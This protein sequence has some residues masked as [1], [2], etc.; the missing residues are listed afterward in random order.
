MSLKRGEI[1]DIHKATILKSFTIPHSLLKEDNK[2][3]SRIDKADS[4]KK[5][6]TTVKNHVIFFW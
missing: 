5:I 3:L 1:H 2:N 6:T 4:Q